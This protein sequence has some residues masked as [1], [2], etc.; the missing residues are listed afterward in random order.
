MCLLAALC[1]CR[2]V[3]RTMLGVSRI[4]SPLTVTLPAINAP[5]SPAELQAAHLSPSL[6]PDSNAPPARLPSMGPRWDG[7]ADLSAQP[8][9]VFICVS[10]GGARATRLAAHTLAELERTYN[11]RLGPAARA[12]PL[13]NQVDGWSSVSGGSVYTSYVASLLATGSAS[14]TNFTYLATADSI[15]WATQ[16]LG[17]L[18]AIFF[19]WPGN[20]GYAPVM[21]VLTEWDTLN[22]FARTHAMFQEKRLPLLPA[23]KLRPLGALPPRPL[24]FFN[25]T[26]LETGRPLI[27]TQSLIHR[28]LGGDPLTRLAPDPLTGWAGAGH[29]PRTY[30]SIPLGYASTLEDLGSSPS[31]FPVAYAVFGSAAFPGVFQPLLL[32]KYELTA[33]PA[34]DTALHCR[35]AGLVTIVDGGL[36]DNTGLVTVLDLFDYL[37]TQPPPGGQPRRLVLLSIDASTDADTYRGP[38]PASPLPLHLD[39]PIRGLIPAVSTMLHYYNQQQF[40]VGAAIRQRLRV[41]QER[42]ALEFFQVNLREAAHNA[43]HLRRI[44][45]DFVLTDREDEWLR[46]AALELLSRQSRPA[47]NETVAEAFVDAVRTRSEGQARP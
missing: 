37:N 47:P 25:A 2:T 23:F 38:T 30:G 12:R 6:T 13:V 33:A 18:A 17:A 41:L 29:N 43:E 1:G 7:F 26:C 3:E 27:F 4:K 32:D 31:R 35:R 5:L 9:T 39:L 15:R 28:D 11:A 14:E 22:L 10:G 16:R 42:G 24:F 45:T 21:Q 34:G 40:L 8:V 20:L 46:E 19:F 36:Y 44:P